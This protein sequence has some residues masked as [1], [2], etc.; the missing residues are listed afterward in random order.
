MKFIFSA[1]SNEF[2]L[3]KLKIPSES[4]LN[5]IIAGSTTIYDERIKERLSCKICNEYDVPSF[6]G[7]P[8]AKPIQCLHFFHPRCVIN[9]KKLCLTTGNGSG[10]LNVLFYC[11]SK[12]YTTYKDLCD[13]D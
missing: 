1:K 11:E 12:I 13:C 3:I 4:E 9:W 10:P 7:I 5:G 6:G 8:S 2:D